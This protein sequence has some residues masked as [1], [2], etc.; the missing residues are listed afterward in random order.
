[1]KG[2]RQCGRGM[3]P[4]EPFLYSAN[5]LNQYVSRT[6]PGW[7]SVRGL[8]ATNAYISVNGNEAFAM[9]GRVVPDAPKYYFGSDDFDNSMQSGWAELETYATL[10]S[11]TNGPDLVSAV[12]NRVFVPQTPETFAYDADG[13][14]I[15]DGRFRYWWNGEN[16]TGT[17]IPDDGLDTL[18]LRRSAMSVA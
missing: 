9:A 14:M 15:E 8:A 3:R 1:M 2:Q 13:N 11:A 7:A 6:V 12:T 4:A 17:L 5:A 16:W 10:S 18:H